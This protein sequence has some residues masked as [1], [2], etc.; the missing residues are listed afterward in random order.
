[1]VELAPNIAEKFSVLL[2]VG[3]HRCYGLVA[4]AACFRE[5]ITNGLDLLQFRRQ[6]LDKVVVEFKLCGEQTEDH[7][8]GDPKRE[9]SLRAT[10]TPAREVKW[11]LAYQRSSPV[12]LSFQE[13]AKSCIE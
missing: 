6:Q 7:G 5:D 10:V 8:E 13:G 4:H 11:Y 12:V 1:M 3:R 2:L 9:D